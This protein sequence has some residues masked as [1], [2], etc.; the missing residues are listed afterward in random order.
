MRIFRRADLTTHLIT[1]DD[2][3]VLDSHRLLKNALASWREGRVSR[4][5]V[6]FSCKASLADLDVEIGAYLF[7]LP[8]NVDDLASTSAL[9]LECWD[10]LSIDQRGLDAA[11]TRLL[12]QLLPG[13]RF[14]DQRS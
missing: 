14:L 7:A 12:R 4:H 13:G 2:I 11:A 5:A 6:C 1:A 9:C 10:A 3:T 8:V